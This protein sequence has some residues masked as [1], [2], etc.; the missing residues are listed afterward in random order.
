MQS[1]FRDLEEFSIACPQGAGTLQG[2]RSACVAAVPGSRLR[3]LPASC[4]LSSG[5]WHK[6]FPSSVNGVVVA[7]RY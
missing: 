7:V 2:L 5:N 1:F 6:S 3:Q 4:L